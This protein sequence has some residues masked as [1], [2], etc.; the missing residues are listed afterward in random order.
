[1][2]WIHLAQDRY[3]RRAA[4]NTSIN[5]RIPQNTR[6]FFNSSACE[7]RGLHSVLLRCEAALQDYFFP[8]FWKVPRSFETSGNANP[9]TQCHIPGDMHAELLA[10]Q[11]VIIQLNLTFRGPCIVIYS[12]N[13]TNEMHYLKF[14]FGVGLYMFRTVSLSI[15]RSL[16]LY[17]QL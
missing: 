4:V 9:A 11:E 3:R 6:N 16:A 13:K 12:F 8:T 2:D 1:M 15:T 17:T 5:I 14:I 7:I 10:S